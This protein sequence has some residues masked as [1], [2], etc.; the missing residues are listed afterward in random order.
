MT[1]L[2]R[3]LE[4]VAAERHF[5]SGWV[6]RVLALAFV[7]LGLGTVAWAGEAV[8]HVLSATVKDQPIPSAEVILQKNGETS[9]KAATD[10][11]GH[12]K[13]A[14]PFGGTDDATV[15][16]IIKKD[17]YSN[18]VVKCPCGGLTYAL[19]PVMQSLDGMRVEL[20]WGAN[21]KDLDSHLV[22]P[23]NH[24]FFNHQ[25]GDAANLDVDCV[26]GF[27][28]ETITLQKKKA[29]VKYLYAVHNYSEG[30]RTGTVS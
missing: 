25:K 2:Q 21:P 16:M 4:A 10:S 11:S 9:V 24:V 12:A 22:F 29:A 14:N 8:V 13:F 15:T 28:P 27:G 6:S 18:L 1:S 23:H 7:V 20:N 3:D 17:G 30:E 5:G 19:S 26:E